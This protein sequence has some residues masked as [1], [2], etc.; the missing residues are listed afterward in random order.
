M[1][2]LY[3]ILAVAAALAVATG[4]GYAAIPSSTGAIS[5]C[6]DSKGALKVID[7]EAG[8][9]CGAG[10]QLLTWN[11]QGPPGPAGGA[12][13][14]ARVGT[15]GHVLEQFAQNVTDA[16]IVKVPDRFGVYCV[17]GLPFAATTAAVTLS[18]DVGAGTGPRNPTPIL[19]SGTTPCPSGSQFLV[20]IQDPA[21]DTWSG[22]DH[23]FWIVFS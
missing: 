2:K 20:S 7:A 13:G 3:I 22:R 21:L 12:L 5:A 18:G 15:S 11:Q 10:K 4:V 23:G 17:V 6:K 8:E 1:K 9:T 16:N 19:G 14:S